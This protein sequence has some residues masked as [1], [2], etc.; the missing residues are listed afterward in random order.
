MWVDYFCP[1]QVIPDDNS[2]YPVTEAEW[3]E[4]KNPAEFTAYYVSAGR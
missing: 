2:I 4:Y 1:I 3:L